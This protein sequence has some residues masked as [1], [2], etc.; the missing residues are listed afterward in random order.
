MIFICINIITQNCF[1]IGRGTR[2]DIISTFIFHEKIYISINIFKE[3]GT[4]D[5]RPVGTSTHAR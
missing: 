1:G 5:F 3:I 2:Y 4:F